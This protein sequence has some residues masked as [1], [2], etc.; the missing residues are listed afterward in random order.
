MSATEEQRYRW[1]ET[2]TEC[3]RLLRAAADAISG[4]CTA[5]TTRTFLEDA[6]RLFAR[7]ERLWEQLRKIEAGYVWS[8]TEA[9]WVAPPR[10]EPEPAPEPEPEPAP[11]P[12]RR[13]FEG[14]AELPAEPIS[15]G[16][17]WL[18]RALDNVM[19]TRAVKNEER[20]EEERRLLRPYED[21]HERG[22][23]A[24][25]LPECE[26]QARPFADCTCG[27]PYR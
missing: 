3:A 1:N 22:E 26:K 5:K 23:R 14:D 25:H 20:R 12:A 27:G 2:R 18:Y 9:C 13:P 21:A 15:A 8:P 4:G 7:Y 11:K 10:F 19:V 17:R 6:E 24:A 16:E